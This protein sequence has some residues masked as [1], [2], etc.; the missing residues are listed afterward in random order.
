MLAKL[1][2]NIRDPPKKVLNALESMPTESESLSPPVHKSAI[3]A[4]STLVFRTFSSGPEDNK[5]HKKYLDLFYDRFTSKLTSDY[6]K[7]Y[8]NYNPLS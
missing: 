4:F 6:S 1:P 5:T 3:L 8:L 7:F 2:F